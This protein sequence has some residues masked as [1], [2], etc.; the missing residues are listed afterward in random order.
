MFKADRKQVSCLRPEGFRRMVYRDWGA[1]LGAPVV[2]CVHGLTRN[3]ADFDALANGLTPDFRV[4]CPDVLGRGDSDWLRDPSGYAY[5]GY[6]QDMAS[7]LARAGVAQVDWVG[8]SMGG[9]IGLLLA[10]ASA[11]PL[12]RL[13]MNDVGPVISADFIRFLKTY[14]GTD[15]RFGSIA[16]AERFLRAAHAG[17]GALTDAQ[18]ATLTLESIRPVEGESSYRLAYDPALATPLQALPDNDVELWAVWDA[19]TIPTLVLRG[20]ESPL[21][22]R[23]MLARMAQRPGVSVAEIPGCGHAPALMDEA[24][25]ALVRNWLLSD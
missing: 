14:V 20:A 15:P 25:I 1:D 23:E 11:T 24:Q 5:D 19:V 4:L 8:T 21:L 18:W 6:V 2:V 13:V 7:L 16:E 9:L 22:D 10:A 3:G 17:F 12:R